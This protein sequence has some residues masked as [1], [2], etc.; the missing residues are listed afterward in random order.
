MLI[1]EKQI[2]L[3]QHFALLTPGGGRFY[4]TV[5]MRVYLGPREKDAPHLVWC[6][7]FVPAPEYMNGGDGN[8]ATMEGEQPFLVSVDVLMDLEGYLSLSNE[9]VNL[10]NQAL[11]GALLQVI[12]RFAWVW[13]ESLQYDPRI[14]DFLEEV[15]GE[16]DEEQE[17]EIDRF[18]PGATT[19]RKYKLKLI[20]L[21]QRRFR[22]ITII[23]PVPPNMIKQR[24]VDPRDLTDKRA[25][26]YL[27]LR[28]KDGPKIDIK[29]FFNDIGPG[30]GGGT[31]EQQEAMRGMG[32]VMVKAALD[33]MQR[34]GYVQTGELPTA[35][36][37]LLAKIT[38]A[39][40]EKHYSY[41][42]AYGMQPDTSV[43]MVSF[44][45]PKV[46]AWWNTENPNWRWTD[47][48]DDNLGR[49]MVGSGSGLLAGTSNIGRTQRW[50]PRYQPYP[51]KSPAQTHP[52]IQYYSIN[53]KVPL[54]PRRQ[55]EFRVVTADGKPLPLIRIPK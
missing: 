7:A 14:Q 45:A 4:P 10:P 16:T 54:P 12:R 1:E 17:F 49:L 22:K 29:E 2:P 40:T 19:G 41:Q 6:R 5:I 27:I 50:G 37:E 47:Q 9:R 39:S 32:S 52:W 46:D 35:Q 31:Y 11:A 24:D 15:E 25:L 28:V 26:A 23:V 34:V 13:M 21:A 51:W 48:Q 55:G 53:P 30:G 44:N 43:P 3:P 42:K 36:V 18:I 20:T 38:D 33:V 8:R